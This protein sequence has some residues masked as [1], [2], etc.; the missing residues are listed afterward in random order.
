MYSLG[1]RNNCF[2]NW[3]I[4]S[5]LLQF[6]VCFR[7]EGH[8][9]RLVLQKRVGNELIFIVTESWYL[10]Q[11]SLPRLFFSDFWQIYGCMAIILLIF[12]QTRWYNTLF[13]P[14]SNNCVTAWTFFTTKRTACRA[15]FT[16]I[17]ELILVLK[18]YGNIFLFWPIHETFWSD[19]NIGC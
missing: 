7:H 18:R 3:C 2:K 17:K 10:I 14:S 16:T 5:F 19:C 9:F 8:S 11:G 1:P 12:S 13:V 4:F 15:K 6:F